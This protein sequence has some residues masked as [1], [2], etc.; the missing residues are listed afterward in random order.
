M[1]PEC[2][3]QGFSSEAQLKQLVSKEGISCE[4]SCVLPRYHSVAPNA[5]DLVNVMALLGSEMCKSSEC[6]KLLEAERAVEDR[7]SFVEVRTEKRKYFLSSK[8]E[9]K[10]TGKRQCWILEC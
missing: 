3:F 6:V 1:F 8:G 9:K 7:G 2:L 5:Q 10:R 4:G